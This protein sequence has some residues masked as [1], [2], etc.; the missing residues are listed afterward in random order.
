MPAMLKDGKVE[1]IVLPL[2]FTAN[3]QVREAT[4]TLATTGEAMG[5]GQLGMWVARAPY[6]AKNR[7]ALLDFMED[8]LRIERWYLDPANREA[9]GKI[10]AEITKWPPER[11]TGWLFK[12]EGQAADYYRNP[13]G[14]PDIASLQKSIDLQQEMGFVKQKIDIKN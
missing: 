8:A 11:W 14:K 1:L 3:P 4:R 12:K 5:I 10:A 2:P 13:D 9:A 6:I 7:A